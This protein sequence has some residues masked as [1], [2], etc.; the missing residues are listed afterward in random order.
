VSAQTCDWF[1][2]SRSILYKA[3]KMQG[4]E[5]LASIE[6]WVGFEARLIA[7]PASNAYIIGVIIPAQCNSAYCEQPN[8]S[9]IAT[10]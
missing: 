5:R 10:H 7:R 4:D 8:L 2:Y 1:C 6:S 3:S 9:K